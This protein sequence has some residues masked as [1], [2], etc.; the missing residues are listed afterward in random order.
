MTK[1]FANSIKRVAAAGA[2][3]A[4]STTASATLIFSNDHDYAFGLDPTAVHI[5]VEHF[6][7]NVDGARV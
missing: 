7:E 4:V 1:R 6:N 5:F 2:L 3:L